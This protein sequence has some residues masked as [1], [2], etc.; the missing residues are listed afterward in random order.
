MHTT[1]T[2]ERHIRTEESS[3]IKSSQLVEQLMAA[4]SPVPSEELKGMLLAAH[5]A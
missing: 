5:T 4:I 3:E 2:T 1:E